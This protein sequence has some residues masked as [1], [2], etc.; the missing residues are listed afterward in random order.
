M[1][2][3][4]LGELSSEKSLALYGLRPYKNPPKKLNL[5]EH[6]AI[7]LKNMSAN[8]YSWS[9]LAEMLGLNAEALRQQVYKTLKKATKELNKAPIVAI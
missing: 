5:T 4:I 3:S 9:E 2:A 8:M 6:D 1:L 7:V